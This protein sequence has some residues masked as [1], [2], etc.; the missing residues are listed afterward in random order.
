MTKKVPMSKKTDDLRKRAE[1]KIPKSAGSIG[2]M[3]PPKIQK[4]VHELDVQQI[5]LEMQNEELRKSQEET[6]ESQHK[7]SDLYDFAPVGYFTFNKKGHIIEANLTGASLL[8]ME[9]RSLAKQSFQRFIVPG[10][11]GVF[12]SHLQKAHETRSKQTCKLKLAGKD[13]SPF[14]ALMDTIAVIDDEGR[15]VYYLSSVTDITDITRTERELREI[16]A[17]YQAI[18]DGAIEGIFRTSLLGK[19]IVANPALARILGYDSA[20][21]VVLAIEDSARQ[22]WSDPNERSSFVRLLEEQGTVRGYE[23]QFKKKDGTKIWVSLNSRA[24]RGTDGQVVYFDGFI[25]DISERKQVE[26]TLRESE[27]RLSLS[28]EAVGAGLWI[29]NVDTGSVWVSPKSRELF[30][31]APDEEIHYESYFRVIHP[32]DRERVHQE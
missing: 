5:E 24:V 11:L 19:N 31:F 20:E 27:A 7:Y 9:K 15:F 3:S 30:H 1:K 16:E 4:L 14:D 18:F 29:M 8:G 25:E 2:K 6:A 17:R 10:H 13:G 26:D 22:V 32:D 28:T 23:C 21:D 12:Q